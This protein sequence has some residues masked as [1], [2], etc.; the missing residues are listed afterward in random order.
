MK[1][2]KTAKELFKYFRDLSK[3]GV[4]EVPLDNITV[5]GCVIKKVGITYDTDGKKRIPC[6]E[7][8][9]TVE[10]RQY[11][12][13]ASCN[14]ELLDFVMSITDKDNDWKNIYISRKKI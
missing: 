13:S 1:S 2:E 10:G 6:N 12:Y 8:E 5:D 9:L 3:K 7:Y 14:E 11:P 4:E